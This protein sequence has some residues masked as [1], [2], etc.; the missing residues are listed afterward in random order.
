MDKK[1]ALSG[2]ITFIT[3]MGIVSLIPFI[4]LG[5][6]LMFSLVGCGKTGQVMDGDGMV[7]E[8]SYAQISQE[9]TSDNAGVEK[10]KL[11]FESFDG[12]GPDFNV[13]IADEGIVSYETEVKV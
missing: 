12:G 6:C 11:S 9:E 1:R 8:P 4:V 10:A 3:L 2:A 5:V 13:L 7:R